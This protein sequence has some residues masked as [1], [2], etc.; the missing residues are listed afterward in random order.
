M[1]KGWKTF[2]FVAL[3][4]FTLGATVNVVRSLQGNGSQNIKESLK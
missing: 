3:G 2:L 4:M 1:N